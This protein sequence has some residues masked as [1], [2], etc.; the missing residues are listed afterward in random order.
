LLRSPAIGRGTPQLILAFNTHDPN[1]ALYVF[2]FTKLIHGSPQISISGQV[3][4]NEQT[5]F[6][7]MA[8]LTHNLNT[9]SVIRERGG[10][11]SEY[12]GA[13]SNVKIDVVASHGITNWQGH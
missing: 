1:H 12:T 13:I 2:Q 11:A 9:Y 8:V 10:D 3:R 6:V 7:T 4:A 5:G